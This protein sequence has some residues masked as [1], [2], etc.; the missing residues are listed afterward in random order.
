MSLMAPSSPCSNSSEI[1]NLSS[2]IHSYYES[3][4]GAVLQGNGNMLFIIHDAFL[5]LYNWENFPTPQEQPNG[6][7]DTHHYEG[8][9]KIA[10]LMAAF[11][12]SGTFVFQ[13]QLNDVCNFGTELASIES[14]IT[15]V[16]GEFSSA[17][18]DCTHLLNLLIKAQS[19]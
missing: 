8:A 16:V 10:M 12:V 17:Q 6:V 7:L 15:T 2:I 5:S 13:D 1:T 19:T 4:I 14:G 11:S 9:A 18:T 3:G